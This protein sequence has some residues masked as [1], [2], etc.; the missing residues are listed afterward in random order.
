MNQVAQVVT[1]TQRRRIAI[2]EAVEAAIRS[3]CT[4]TFFCYGTAHCTRANTTDRERAG[5]AF[6]FLHTD[7]TAST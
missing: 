2:S 1:P 6:H 7:Y 4:W 5:M 3:C